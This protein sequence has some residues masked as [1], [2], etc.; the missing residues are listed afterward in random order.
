MKLPVSRFSGISGLFLLLEDKTSGRKELLEL[1]TEL[2]YQSSE[3]G[4]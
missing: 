3:N 4:F 1:I 2:Y